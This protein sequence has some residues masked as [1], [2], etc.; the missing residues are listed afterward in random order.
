MTLYDW[1]VYG[2][3]LFLLTLPWTIGYLPGRNK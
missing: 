2:T 3:W 1:I